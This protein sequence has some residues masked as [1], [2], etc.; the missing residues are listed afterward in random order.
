MWGGCPDNLD[1]GI[2]F[3]KMFQDE[4][5]MFRRKRE[6]VRTAIA[7]HNENVGRNVGVPKYNIIIFQL[8]Y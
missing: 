3:S 4:H 5:L 6:S 2:A 8:S 7:I 1:F